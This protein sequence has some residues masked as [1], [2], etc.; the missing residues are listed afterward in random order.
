MIFNQLQHC[1]PTFFQRPTVLLDKQHTAACARLCG[2]AGGNT[3]RPVQR[4]GGGDGQEER[5]RGEGQN[6][7]GKQKGGFKT[8]EEKPGR[9]Q[10]PLSLYGPAGQ[11]GLSFGIQSEG[12]INWC[13]YYI[14]SK[15]S[16]FDHLCFDCIF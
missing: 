3:L 16:F 11:A 10:R 1:R 12:M 2:P 6:H 9:K 13:M 5:H 7:V 8:P 15:N 14:I 4:P